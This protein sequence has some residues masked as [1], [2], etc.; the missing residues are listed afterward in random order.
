MVLLSC[1]SLAGSSCKV[2][3][4]STRECKI[5]LA[6]MPASHTH[7][8]HKKLSGTT[9]TSEAAASKV[10]WWK[11]CM[12]IHSKMT[13]TCLCSRHPAHPI[14]HP[15]QQL[16]LRQTAENKHS[17]LAVEQSA[18]PRTTVSTRWGLCVN[19][20]TTC[21]TTF[22]TSSLGPKMGT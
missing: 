8:L 4:A 15:L 13:L 1:K 21:T 7:Q 6:T 5:R 19:P 3:A 11:R 9:S 10:I 14:L 18:P 16:C 17:I 2:A 20:V 22:C 12:H